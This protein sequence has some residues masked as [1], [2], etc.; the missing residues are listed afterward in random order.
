MEVIKTVKYK[1]LLTD[2]QKQSLK[3][4]I[5]AYTFYYNWIMKGLFYTSNNLSKYDLHHLVYHPIKN[6]CPNLNSD[7]INTLIAVSFESYKSQQSLAKNGHKIANKPVYSKTQ[8]PRLNRHLFSYSLKSDTFSIASLDGRLKN[9]QYKCRPG[10]SPYNLPH[11]LLSAN[12]IYDRKHDKFYLHSQVK[13]ERELSESKHNIGCDMGVSFQLVTFG[14]NEYQIFHDGHL[15][16]VDKHYQ[17]LR[18]DLQSKGTR[19]SKRRLKSIGAKQSRLRR[20]IDHII[21]KSLVEYC[22]NNNLDTIAVEDLTNIRRMAKRGKN[23]TSNR[24]INMWSYFR[25]QSF[26]EYKANFNYINLVKINPAYTS[27]TCPLCDCISKKNRA[28]RDTFKCIQCGLTAMSDYIAAYNIY[29]LSG[30]CHPAADAV[31]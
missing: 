9:I 27:T 14:N 4:T 26:I 29:K 24:K 11:K 17:A 13:F 22:I 7:Y 1:L 18:K 19:S 23:K 5:N 30:R 2:L 25:L 16:E 31:V 8:S 21:S 12:L 28:S 3:H 10:Y 6:A 15:I 20:E